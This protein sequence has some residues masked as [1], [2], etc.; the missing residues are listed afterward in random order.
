MTTSAIR[1]TYSTFPV[2]PARSRRSF[3]TRLNE[4]WNALTV[5][6]EMAR[7]VGESGHVG[8]SQVK[9]VRAIAERL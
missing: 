1:A 6:M 7:I 2:L 4:L 9:E 3:G 5:S 8:A